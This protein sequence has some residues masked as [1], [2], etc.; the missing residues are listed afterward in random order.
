MLDWHKVLLRLR[1]HYAD[2]A[3]NPRERFTVGVTQDADGAPAGSRSPRCGSP[4]S[5][6]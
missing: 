1:D 6:T 4:W 2:P 5:T 3:A